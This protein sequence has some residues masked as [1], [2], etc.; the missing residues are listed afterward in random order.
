[1]VSGKRF[2]DIW[3]PI[4]G[5]VLIGISVGGIVL[6]GLGFGDFSYD[7]G[8][9][10][11]KNAGSSGLN[12]GSALP[13]FNLTSLTGNEIHLYDFRGKVVIIN[14]WATWC[15]PCRLE[16]PIL[17]NTYEKYNPKLTVFAINAGESN[18]LV[19]EYKEELQLTFNILLDPDRAMEKLY[20]LRGFPT[21]FFIDEEGTL[22]A[23]HVGAL[24]EGQLSEY[25]R[26]LGIED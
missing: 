19:Q 5:G 21:T 16:M 18:Y 2:T 26:Q 25:L 14:F 9:F 6:F 23:R 13:N 15:A 10:L 8:S 1:M 20:H 11:E 7:N 12:L 3:I 17:Q 4:L 24:T 22:I